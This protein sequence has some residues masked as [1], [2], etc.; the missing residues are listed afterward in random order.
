MN[1]K[2]KREFKEGVKLIIQLVNTM[3]NSPLQPRDIDIL[4]EFLLLPV[5]TEHIRYNAKNKRKVIK[6][7]LLNYN[8]SLNQKSISPIILRLIRTKFLEKQ[9]DKLVYTNK[10]LRQYIDYYIKNKCIN[11]AITVDSNNTNVL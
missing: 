10:K 2:T 3:T 8:Y 9:E 7:A 4:T 1:I 5:E 6:L 11:I